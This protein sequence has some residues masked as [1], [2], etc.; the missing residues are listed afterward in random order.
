MPRKNLV[1]KQLANEVS[2]FTLLKAELN[3]ITERENAFSAGQRAPL[4]ET[5]EA[6]AK[7]LAGRRIELIRRLQKERPPGG[8]IR[9]AKLPNVQLLRLVIA[10]GRLFGSCN[11]MD[12]PIMAEGPS[13][14]PGAPGTSG[15]ID[16]VP[17]SLWHG[18]VS[19]E[20][21]LSNT[22]QQKPSP[23]RLWSREW[24]WTVVFPPAPSDGVISFNFVVDCGVHVVQA[25]AN[26]GYLG[27]PISMLTTSDAASQPLSNW[28]LVGW[29][30]NISLPQA[31]Y[32][33]D[34]SLPVSGT[35]AVKAG[36]QAAVALFCGVIV[37]LEGGFCSFGPA[38][39][40]YFDTRLAFGQPATYGFID[41]CF[42]PTWWIDAVEAR[43]AET[44]RMA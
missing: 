15:E 13:Y 40:S 10:V 17:S 5:P 41:Y 28:T 36:R 44:L 24:N 19:Y 6:Y 30:T 32:K 8:V 27:T 22:D 21:Y 9:A 11:E 1:T 39:Y 2:S 31:S 20:G 18:Q 37:G 35:I 25:P 34:S 38:P 16:T 12:V 43:S 29:P 26:V 33:S 14:T 3:L 4:G 7:R 42:N 23:E